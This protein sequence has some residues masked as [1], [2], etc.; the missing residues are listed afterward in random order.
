M[1]LQQWCQEMRKYTSVSGRD[2]WLSA[3][4]SA[5]TTCGCQETRKQ[6]AVSSRDSRSSATSI[7]YENPGTWEACFLAPWARHNLGTSIGQWTMSWSGLFISSI[8]LLARGP[9]RP[10]LLLWCPTMLRRCSSFMLAPEQIQLSTN[11]SGHDTGAR[12]Q[13]VNTSH[14][15]LGYLEPL[16]QPI[17]S[18]I[19]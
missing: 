19:F 13:C 9:L 12:K 17:F 11:H 2:S 4:Q 15:H 1:W 8:S 14:Q 5:N 10:L 3:T 7:V 18:I 6:K 16:S